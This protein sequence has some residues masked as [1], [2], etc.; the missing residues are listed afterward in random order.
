MDHDGNQAMD[1]DVLR[2]QGELNIYTAMET[3]ER[4]LA[5][6]AAGD[7]LDIDLSGVTE[8]DTSGVQLLIL[9]KREAARQGKRLALSGHSPAAMDLIDLFNLGGWFGD[10]LIIPAGRH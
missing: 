4:L 1:G 10:P 7:A 5:A 6:L 2:L 8:M 9:A 3:K